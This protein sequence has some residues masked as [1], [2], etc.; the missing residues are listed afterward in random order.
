M[1]APLTHTA[2][3]RTDSSAGLLDNVDIRQ[4]VMMLWRRKLIGAVILLAVLG[5]TYVGLANVTPRYTAT[6][7][8]VL[9]TRDVQVND[10]ESVVS[11]MSN[12]TFMI[13][14]ELDVLHSRALAERVV[15]ELGLMDDPEFND[16]IDTGEGGLLAKLGLD[17]LLSGR[18]LP[19]LPDEAGAA[20]PRDGAPATG[21]AVEAP[22]TAGAVAPST[23]EMSGDGS[24]VSG[25]AVDDVESP[26][27]DGGVE[28][29]AGP[30]PLEGTARDLA[31]AESAGEENAM[32]PAEQEELADVA[33]ALLDRLTVFNTGRSYTVEIAFQSEDPQ[34]AARIVNTV[35]DQYLTSQLE[36]K[37][38]ETE[39]IAQWLQKK[40][41]ELRQ[42]MR[43]AED[44]LQD[45]LEANNIVEMGESTLTMSQLQ[46]V[47][48]QVI[49]AR[50]R[51][52]AA[53]ARLREA[54]Q[55][56]SSDSRGA[57]S[58]E[59]SGAPLIQNLRAQEITLESNLAQLRSDFGARHPRVVNAQAELA[60]LRSRIQT[61]INRVV[62]SLQSEVQVARMEEE[63]LQ[64]RADS[65]TRDIEQANRAAVQQRELEAE[66]Q[67]A[68]SLFESFLDS[69][70][71]IS[72]Q[73]DTLQAD[74][75]ILSYAQTP[76]TPSYPQKKSV[77]ILAF[78]GGT[79]LALAAILLVEYV[80]NSVRRADAVERRF[81]V[82][83]LG[84]VPKVRWRGRGRRHPSRFGLVQ[85]FSAYAESV[86]TV[87]N[88]VRL[89][90]TEGGNRVILVTSSSP[91][92]GKSAL[93]LSMA[94]SAA[95][96][97]EQVLLIDADFRA[98]SV[99]ADMG[100]PAKVGLE[101]LL[102]GEATLDEVVQTDEETGLR[103]IPL[104]RRSASPMALI[105]SDR[106]RK[107]IQQASTRYDLVVVDSPSLSA[108]SDAVVLSRSVDATVLA[109]RWGRTPMPALGAALKRLRAGGTVP[110]G[111]VLTQ[112]DMARQA[113]YGL[114]EHLAPASA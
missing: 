57:S 73:F 111:V 17:S 1:N 4:I 58:A 75:R 108:S 18:T 100:R 78:L 13:R 52:A 65:L 46:S 50:A 101:H 113:K 99:A 93:A 42:N 49:D 51:R 76:G 79:V 10:L 47:D 30:A 80:D 5:L 87:R 91:G 24:A 62:D 48:R 92:E 72:V 7:V 112:V 28:G 114:S 103:Y 95:S 31:L 56:L 12:D 86:R 23:T 36:A 98:P 53:E 2:A 63:E 70:T 88:A 68:R 77:M 20:A 59:V 26:V 81:G 66:A 84:M 44:R 33:S 39:R 96:M 82:S 107:L 3:A 37:Y 54:R 106:M 35:A 34:K 19:P 61:E 74:A 55:L 67:A 29:D 102:S 9:N 71:R 21:E 110:A 32:T 105:G 25:I 22:S 94:R 38:A 83:V 14:S 90:D 89:F 27:I 15:T 45:F 64:S 104:T 97:S 85:P 8:L 69:F 16:R 109:V 11:G 41:G 40:I 60:E 6:A 43:R